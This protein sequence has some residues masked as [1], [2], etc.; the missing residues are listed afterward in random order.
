MNGLIA[1]LRGDTQQRQDTRW[2]QAIWQQTRRALN[3]TWPC[4]V[5]A[6]VYGPRVLSLR[7]I[8]YRMTDVSKIEGSAGPRVEIALATSPVTVRRESGKLFV[9]VPVPQD[10]QWQPWADRLPAMQ[11]PRVPLG[12][13]TLTEVF[14]W[15]FGAHPHMILTGASGA[16]KSTAV[17][18]MVS[19]LYGPEHFVIAVDHKPDR[20]QRMLAQLDGARYASFISDP[21]EALMCVRW[22]ISTL[23]TRARD[24]AGEEL[25]LIL[26]DL[27]ALLRAQPGI[28]DPLG[29]LASV[30][31]SAGVHVILCA[32]ETSVNGIGDTLVGRNIPDRIV[33]RVDSAGTAARAAGRAD[34]PAHLLTGQGDAY[35]VTS[36]G[37]ARIQIAKATERTIRNA[38][39]CAGG[40]FSV[41][42][43]V[44]PWMEERGVDAED[45]DA[46]EDRE[47]D[48]WL[49]P[50]VEKAR[51]VWERLRQPDGNMPR[52]A[53]TELVFT[54]YG[55]REVG[56]YKGTV[57]QVWSRLEGEL[58]KEGET[59]GK[60][61]YLEKRRKIG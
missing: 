31:R 20:T 35:A 37:V 10:R 8:P 39:D 13:T 12:V 30:S 60:V 28:S 58:G 41:K 27:P 7:V 56:G 42:R 51:P 43:E 11:W 53:L 61:V 6:P 2:L 4:D 21:A 22:L 55:K 18:T 24:A 45:Q 26:D 54:L 14:A 5:L 59:D 33:L 38:V 47:E 16:G 50:L 32:Q 49:A 9:E 23:E 19:K 34:V 29:V 15:D 46:L 57:M 48:D 17:A 25:F 52:G 3:E 36:E 1:R 44:W 40:R